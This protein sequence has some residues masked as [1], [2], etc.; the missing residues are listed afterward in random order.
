MGSKN[1]FNLEGVSGTLE[2]VAQA[3]LDGLKKVAPSKTTVELG[4][5]LAIKNGKLSGLIVA[6]LFP[7][8]ER[9]CQP[10]PSLL[11][12]VDGVQELLHGVH[13]P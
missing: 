5:Q 3:V 7:H 8:R 13:R 9:E 12:L 11:A 1:T 2:G 6:E 4:I 10:R